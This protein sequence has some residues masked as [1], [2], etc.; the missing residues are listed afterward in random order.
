LH[1]IY[2]SL[3]SPYRCIPLTQRNP[4]RSCLNFYNNIEGNIDGSIAVPGIKRVLNLLINP[5]DGSGFGQC[6][7]PLQ[8]YFC[9]YFF[10]PCD[11]ETNQIIPVCSWSCNLLYNNE[12]CLDWLN[13]VRGI[14]QDELQNISP[15]LLPDEDSCTR[16]F[17]PISE[18]SVSGDCK[19]IG[20]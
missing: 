2:L 20:G 13:I 9:Y 12:D 17:L 8:E 16:N 10:P 15:L 4:P 3:C 19:R 18:S 7:E 1:S 6:V 11:L 14:M 5:S